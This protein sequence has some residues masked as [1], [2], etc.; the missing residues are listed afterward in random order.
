M[1]KLFSCEVVLSQDQSGNPL[2]T[3]PKVSITENEVKLLRHIH[4]HDN[5]RKMVDAGSIEREQRNDL[6]ILARVYGDNV[7]AAENRGPRLI[8]KIFG[9]ELPEFE[10]WLAEQ[11]ES[12]EMER[13]NKQVQRESLAKVV[14]PAAPQETVDTPRAERVAKAIDV[15]KRALSKQPEPADHLE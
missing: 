2:L 5:I 13:Q 14:V 9:V 12:E 3:V 6:L 15:A 7:E 11:L 1:L 10:G 4:G 8:S